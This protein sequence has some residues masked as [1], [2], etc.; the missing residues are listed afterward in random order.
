[1]L[2]ISK[3]RNEKA[4]NDRIVSLRMAAVFRMSEHKH[5]ENNTE[6]S[7]TTHTS[8]HSDM[9]YRHKMVK[10]IANNSQ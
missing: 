8:Q 1:M 3:R 7:G 6:Q 5:D 10:E 4:G 2:D 9:S